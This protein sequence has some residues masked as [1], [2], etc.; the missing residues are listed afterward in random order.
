MVDLRALVGPVA[1]ACALAAS[2]APAA[3]QDRF[4]TRVGRV[5]NGLY[6]RNSTVIRL[7]PLGLFDDLRVGYRHR[8]F[9]RPANPILLRNTYWGVAGSLAASPGFVRGGAAVEFAPLAMLNFS[10]AFERVQ[11]FGTF[12]FVQSYAS[13]NEGFS[14]A[15]IR[16]RARVDPAS[17]EAAGG[18]MLTLQG[19]VQAKVG[20]LAI[21]NTTRGVWNSLSL[22][23]DRPVFYD[24]FYDVMSPDGGWVV[25]DDL[26]LI[27]QNTEMGFN[28]GARFTAVVPLYEQR[29]WG[30]DGI[31]LPGAGAD[32]GP[33][34]R[35]GPLVSYTFREG[36][37]S[38]F[39]A[40][41]VFVLAQWWLTHRYRTGG[42][43]ECI[44]QG[45]PMIVVGFAFRGDS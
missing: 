35:V 20:D 15:A 40:P 1:L 26:D 44:P 37:H 41:T 9:D 33:T 27:Y 2:P 10:A 21:R 43:D 17:A 11:W 45:L 31:A 19:I 24:S 7:N 3:A 22:R 30:Q 25:T 38:F 42:C 5:T 39:N 36:R 28:V 8:I 18:W 4:N 29:S 6:L 12:N 13:A 16:E 32:N 14:D 34:L 23:Q